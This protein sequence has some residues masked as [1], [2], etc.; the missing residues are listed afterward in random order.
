MTDVRRNVELKATDLDPERSLQVCRA[1]GARDE[2]TLW[3]RDTYFAVARGRL[4]LREQEPGVPHLIGYARADRPEQR[5]SRYRI[6]ALAGGA[7]AAATRAMLEAALGIECVVVKERRLFLWHD[8]RIHLDRVEGLGT[9]IEL[10]AVAPADSDLSAE[11][12]RVAQLREAL[13]ISDERLVAQG[14]AD[15]LRRSRPSYGCEILRQGGRDD[16]SGAVKPGN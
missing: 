4:K 7:D 5:E 16:V 8:V 1:L 13:A 14:Y 15:Q 11:H 3:Q 12:E 9:F 2:G 10:E 6:A